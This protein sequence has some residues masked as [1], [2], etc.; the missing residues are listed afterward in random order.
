M[1]ILCIYFYL[2]I[3]IIYTDSEDDIEIENDKT[4]SENT[5]RN[6]NI[7]T[8]D[9]DTD[10]IKDLENRDFDDDDPP[11]QIV[12]GTVVWNE[13]WYLFKR[14]NIFTLNIQTDKWANS[15]DSDQMAPEGAI[16]SESTQFAFP[17][18]LGL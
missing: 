5:E 18:F 14:L 17:I 11:V 4:T 12:R 6:K 3:P 2:Q 13:L 1:I 10:S 15:V 8:F 9:L 16:W 7:P